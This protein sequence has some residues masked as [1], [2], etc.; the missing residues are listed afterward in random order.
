MEIRKSLTLMPQRRVS[1]NDAR[2]AA[3]FVL[4]SI[5]TIGCGS[6]NP[7]MLNLPHGA[8][9]V[10]KIDFRELKYDLKNHRWFSA[11]K[12]FFGYG[13]DSI[14]DYRLPDMLVYRDGSDSWSS[15]LAY[16]DEGDDPSYE[17][18]QRLFDQQGIWVIMFS[19]TPPSIVNNTTVEN[20]SFDTVICPIVTIDTSYYTII[21]HHSFPLG[22]KRGGSPTLSKPSRLP[23]VKL[24]T[25]YDT[26]YK[27][28]S[29]VVFE[30]EARHHLKTPGGDA[31]DSL[32]HWE[33]QREWSDTSEIPQASDQ[34]PNPLVTGGSGASIS[35]LTTRR[36]SRLSA[37]LPPQIAVQIKSSSDGGKK[38]KVWDHTLQTHRVSLSKSST[39]YDTI[40]YGIHRTSL[41]YTKPVGDLGLSQLISLAASL[42][43]KAPPPQETPV[44]SPPD[45]LWTLTHWRTLTNKNGESIYFA[46][47]KFPLSPGTLNRISISPTLVRNG[48]AVQDDVGGQSKLFSVNNTFED[49]DPSWMNI[50]AGVGLTGGSPQ[51]I[52]NYPNTNGYL[53]LNFYFDRPMMPFDNRS[54]GPVVGLG[55]T[56][57]LFSHIFLGGQASVS[58]V[59]IGVPVAI[60]DVYGVPIIPAARLLGNSFGWWGGGKTFFNSPLTDASMIIPILVRLL[61]S[62]LGWWGGDNSFWRPKP[63]FT[64]DW[65]YLGPGSIRVMAG[66]DYGGG[67]SA[68]CLIG[69]SYDL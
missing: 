42:V 25:A 35:M 19:D 67:R 46:M 47:Q 58:A 43:I 28:D 52:A 4:I 10:D 65:W 54:W 6:N 32:I 21:K 27:R 38:D 23:D 7:L 5:L 48:K 66:G 29:S 40:G 57:G 34:G 12:T 50:G 31:F 15:G 11:Q 22:K 51:S 39:E 33:D 68:Q 9:L 59:L 2:V 69:L 37:T 16:H 17:D 30:Y 64:N 44:T 13:V 26:V 8:R 62:D 49:A 60:Y 36:A 14:Y 55:L 41:A 24:D 18:A 63:L 56:S 3:L 20:T 45:S 1:G 61:G 53:L